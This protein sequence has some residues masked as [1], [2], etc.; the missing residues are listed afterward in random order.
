[1][2]RLE[3][4]RNISAEAGRGELVFPSN[5]KALLKLKQALED[6]DAHLA[7][8]AKMVLAEPLLSARTVALA[9]SVAYNRSGNEINNVTTAVMRLGFRTLRTLVASI[10][11]Q[12]MNSK[13]GDPALEAK[14]AQLW[15]HTAHVAAL[16]QVLA[17]RLTKVDPETAM[18][19][20]IVHEVG[21]FYLLSRAATYP[22]LLDG[23]LE[24]WVEYGEKIIGRS[25]MKAL[26]VPDSISAAIEMIWQ[27]NGARP[28]V[29][30]GDVLVLAN[31]LAPV[32]SPLHPHA[33]LAAHEAA[34]EID[35]PIDGSTLSIVLQEAAEE[36]ESINAAL[37]G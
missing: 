14:G 30:L 33:T 17:R 9:N 3:A 34:M 13:L 27:D 32:L 26:E 31:H 7:N 23:A 25:V 22:G 5:V 11:V 24:D 8:C 35:F 4:F 20:G 18:F 12:Q 2:D 36:I 19:A 1:M 15:K 6:P 21:G 16:A 37:L 29:T 10:M 28:P